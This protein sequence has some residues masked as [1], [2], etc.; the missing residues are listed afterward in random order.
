MDWAWQLEQGNNTPLPGKSHYAFK[1]DLDKEVKELVSKGAAK[2]GGRL[3][4]VLVTGALG[5]CGKGSV[6]STS[7]VIQC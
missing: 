1:D 5:R 4:R 7:I 2:N 3:P 6:Y